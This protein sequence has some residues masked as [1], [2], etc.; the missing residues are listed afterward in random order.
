MWYRI[1][2]AMPLY[3]AAVFLS[4]LLL[5]QIQ[6]AIAKAI[7]PWFGGTASLWTVS[8]LFFEVVLLLGYLYSHLLTTL[9][10]PAWQAAVHIAL[11]GASVLALPAVPDAAWKN[12]TGTEPSWTILR[13]LIA[14]AGLPCFVLSSSG[15]LLQA[16]LARTHGRTVPYRLYAVSNF[17]CLL[18]L[19]AYPLVVE[20]LLTAHGYLRGWSILYGGFAAISAV[21]AIAAL[22]ARGAVPKQVSQAAASASRWILWLLLPASG[23]ALLLSITNHL[24]Q[25]VAPIPLL[26]VVPLGVYLLTFVLAFGSENRYRPALF[27]VLLIPS[28]AAMAFL[29]TTFGAAA[30]LGAALAT[31]WTGL[32]VCCMFC[33]GELA[34]LKPDPAGLTAFYCAIALGG[35][36]GGAFVAFLAPV[37]YSDYAELPVSMA[38]C[39]ILAALITRGPRPESHA[40]IAAAGVIALIAVVAPVSRI[41]QP[42]TLRYRSFYGVFRVTET[43]EAGAR[44][45]KLYSGNTLH[46]SQFVSPELRLHPTA[47]YGPASGA[48]MV[49]RGGGPARR[50]GIIG[51]G[52]GT[53]AAYARPGDVFRFYEVSP[54]VLTVAESEFYFLSDCRGRCDVVLGDGRLSLEREPPQNFDV[55]VLDAFSGDSVPVHLLTAEAFALYA[56]HL[57][58][59]GVLAVHISN[60]YLNLARIISAACEPVGRAVQVIRSGPDPARAIDT[61]V[62]AL[63]NPTGRGHAGPRFHAWTDDYSSIFDVLG[64]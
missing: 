1:R 4:G 55:L 5:F 56:R 58:P 50:V 57:A 49:L 2:T 40:R 30:P 27:R 28:L 13:I 59:G 36:F 18:G 23:T 8:M 20:P 61:A 43:G 25:E 31:F 12:H 42:A 33:H 47:Y 22:R 7:L 10:R 14:T 46:G 60:R 38:A 26:W 15:P 45:R 9:L 52:V 24:S 21:V 34:R 39:A 29:L 16:W 6:P 51:L 19:F 35:A 48:G 37:L 64:R 3:A 63:A 53:L 41:M 54:L 17:A 32:F 62:W 11:V 44:L